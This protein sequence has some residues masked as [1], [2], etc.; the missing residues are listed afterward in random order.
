MPIW[1]MDQGGG[2]DV[3]VGKEQLRELSDRYGSDT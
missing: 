1:E 3:E 2:R